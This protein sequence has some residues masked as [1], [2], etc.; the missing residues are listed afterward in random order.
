MGTQQNVGTGSKSYVYPGQSPDGGKL[1]IH[2]N[3][4]SEANDIYNFISGGRNA[5][6]V[7]AQGGYIP[8]QG[9]TN[10]PAPPQEMDTG[11][12]EDGGGY[13]SGGG[14]GSLPPR[15]LASSPE[16]LA[17]LN[18]LGLEEGMFRAD[19]DRQR[20]LAKSAAEFQLAGLEPQYKAQR[21]QIAH[22][23]ESAGMERS[24]GFLKGLADSRARQGQDQS[25]INFGL[26][27]TL[28]GLESNLAGKLMD[29]NARR[30]QQELSLRSA[31]YV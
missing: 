19:I 17:Y 20:S 7:N 8:G 23:S 29:L 22:R 14:G 10:Y 30:A 16:W 24:G 12:Y 9:Q 25:A 18:A 13:S 31:G 1:I 26:G 2:A 6:I 11:G 4:S 21:G 27:S 28:S 15:Q 3:S 5:G